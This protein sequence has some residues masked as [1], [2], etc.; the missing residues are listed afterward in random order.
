VPTFA[1]RPTGVVLDVPPEAAPPDAWTGVTDGTFE[2]GITTRPAGEVREYYQSTSLIA[3]PQFVMHAG[4]DASAIGALDP[5]HCWWYVGN[6]VSSPAVRVHE[7]RDLGGA[8]NRTPASWTTAIGAAPNQ[9]TGG[10][11]NGIPFVNVISLANS[12]AYG[13]PGAA[14]ALTTLVPAAN[15]IFRAVRAYRYQLVGMGVYNGGAGTDYSTRVNWTA[16]AAPGAFPSTWA[17]SAG[18]DAGSFDVP[19][20]RGPLVDGGQLGEDFMLYAEGSTHVMTYTGGAEIMQLRGVARESGVLSRNCWADVG[21]GHVVLTTSD[22]VL[23][24]PGGVQSIADAS[25]RRA[26]FGPNGAIRPTSPRYAHVIYHRPR[27]EVWVC[28]P[29]AGDY[30]DNAL[31]WHIPTARWGHRT[32]ANRQRSAAA[33]RTA[34]YGTL[35]TRS[36]EVTLC[37]SQG[38][39]A[40]LTDGRLYYADEPTTSVG[41]TYQTR[42]P[43]LSRQDMD[44]GE[45]GRVKLVR[46]IRPRFQEQGSA[47]T[48]IEVRA[49]GRNSATEAIAWSGWAAYAP[50]TDDTV[51]LFATGRL[52]SVELRHN[53]GTKPWR[54]TGL[55]IDFDLRGRW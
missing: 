3:V 17:A 39:A 13:L 45:P 53:D 43:V 26:L 49:G 4:E 5:Q 15:D 16:S 23:A 29:T 25:V 54:L 6:T 12:L 51:H 31:V 46:A 10:I 47:V 32:L 41:G 24:T 55:D 36:R 48:G 8:A 11:L 1:F 34:L 50:T 27:R 40:A 18:N 42:S 44:L 52:I 33:G 14:T 9:V 2:A 22:V 30:C 37:A 19:Y 20:C 38:A 21:V 28:Y 7:V 35:E